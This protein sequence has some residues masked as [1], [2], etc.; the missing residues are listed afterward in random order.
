MRSAVRRKASSG[1]CN[2]HEDALDYGLQSL[3]EAAPRSDERRSPGHATNLRTGDRCRYNLS[4]LITCE[5]HEL[6]N[7]AYKHD[8]DYFVH[9]LMPFARGSE[10]GNAIYAK[11]LKAYRTG[12]EVS[13]TKKCIE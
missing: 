5:V 13:L 10:A 11:V 8:E 7:T 12:K 2:C 1:I 4:R 6:C 9:T 3:R